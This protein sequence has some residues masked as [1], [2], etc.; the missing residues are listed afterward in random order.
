MAW[1][2]SAGLPGK[3]DARPG[4]GRTRGPAHRAG[5]QDHLLTGEGSAVRL[6]HQ[7]ELSDAAAEGRGTVRPVSKGPDSAARGPPTRGD[8]EARSN[9]KFSHASEAEA[10]WAASDSRGKART[11]P[12]SLG[13]NAGQLRPKP[14]RRPIRCMPLHF[15]LSLTWKG[16]SCSS[17]PV[18]VTET[19]SS[20]LDLFYAFRSIGCISFHFQN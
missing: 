4:I 14:P 12:V 11:A 20:L 3:R 9:Q 19:R 1:G 16:S 5:P 8:S 13:P 10:A 15:F 17:P 7:W 6:A 18:K 2:R